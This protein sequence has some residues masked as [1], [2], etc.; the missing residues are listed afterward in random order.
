VARPEGFEPPTLCFEGR[1]SIQLSYGRADITDSKSFIAIW[2]IILKA[3]TLYRMGRRSI[4]TELQA[5]GASIV[6]SCSSSDLFNG[7]SA[8][9]RSIQ[10]NWC[11]FGRKALWFKS[12]LRNQTILFVLKDLLQQG[13][14][15][16][17]GFTTRRSLIQNLV[18]LLRTSTETS[19]DLA[20]SQWSVG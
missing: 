3:L 13:K 15:F 5:N 12:S 18:Q 6:S 4:L 10:S 20:E 9:S 14:L 11:F 2:D 19:S 16:A 1:R 8:D 7:S 17:F